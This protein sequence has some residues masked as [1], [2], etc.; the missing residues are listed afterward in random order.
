MRAPAS[1]SLSMTASSVSARAP[2]S[3]AYPLLSI[4]YVVNAVAAYYL[5]GESLTTAKIKSRLRSP[6][7]LVKWSGR[8]GASNN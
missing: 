8:N 1:T 5:F 7:G 6:S 3:V 2:V 4:G